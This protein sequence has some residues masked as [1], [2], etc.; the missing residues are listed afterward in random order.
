V[1]NQ[2]HVKTRK[3]VIYVKENVLNEKTV[4][5]KRKLDLCKAMEHLPHEIRVVHTEG[6]NFYM[7]CMYNNTNTIRNEKVILPMKKLMRNKATRCPSL[8]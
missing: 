2:K 4:F 1:T 6:G 7:S 8:Q 5:D 3:N